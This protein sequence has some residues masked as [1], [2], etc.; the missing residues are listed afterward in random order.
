MS[1]TFQSR[2]ERAGVSDVVDRQVMVRDP[3]GVGR[4][5]GTGADQLP[6]SLQIMVCSPCRRKSS[7]QV[8]V[9]LS[10]TL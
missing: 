10:C 3:Q 5:V 4:Q 9:M 6:P 2:I 1:F 8:Y 7:L